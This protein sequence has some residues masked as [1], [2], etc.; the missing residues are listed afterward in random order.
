MSVTN[1]ITKA[2]LVHHECLSMLE[3]ECISLYSGSDFINLTKLRLL[4]FQKEREKNAK[5]QSQKEPTFGERIWK[6]LKDIGEW[7]HVS[8]ESESRVSGSEG[9]VTIK[10]WG[11]NTY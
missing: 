10:V 3:D 11:K 1:A 9:E 4:M 6:T 5:K 7:V 2:A 8:E